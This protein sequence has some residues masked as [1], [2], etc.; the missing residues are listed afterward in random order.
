MKDKNVI[1]FYSQIGRKNV[2]SNYSSY[3]QGGAR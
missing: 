1:R 2:V 3:L